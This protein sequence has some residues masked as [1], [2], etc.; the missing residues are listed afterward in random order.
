MIFT[1]SVNRT[2]SEIL[3]PHLFLIQNLLHYYR[4]E[5]VCLPPHAQIIQHLQLNKSKMVFIFYQNH[6]QILLRNV[7]F[8]LCNQCSYNSFRFLL[9]KTDQ[10]K[11]QRCKR[12]LLQLAYI[13]D[14]FSCALPT[15]YTWKLQGVLWANVV[16][17]QKLRMVQLESAVNE[18]NSSLFCFH[19]KKK[20]IKVDALKYHAHHWL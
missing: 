2:N 8:V 11:A 10:W 9:K 4:S 15:V 5:P 6:W 19:S 12:S 16:H 14:Y 17:W 1:A 7:L 3:K 20:K 18:Q 13:W